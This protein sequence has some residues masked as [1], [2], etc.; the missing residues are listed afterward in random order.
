MF[1]YDY[2]NY[3]LGTPAP[4]VYNTIFLLSSVNFTLYNIIIDYVGTP[5][6]QPIIPTDL[7]FT[8]DIFNPINLNL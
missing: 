7:C 8:Q 4:L 1:S 2:N 3:F 5:L 6:I